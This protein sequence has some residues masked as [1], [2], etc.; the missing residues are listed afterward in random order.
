MRRVATVA[1]AAVIF[2]LLKS[3]L[4]HAAPAIVRAPE[5][6]AGDNRVSGAPPPSDNARHFPHAWTR[7]Q[8]TPEHNAAF[9]VADDAPAWMRR[10]VD[11]R[12]AAHNALP[13]EGDAYQN[14]PVNTTQRLGFA[15]GVSAV[16]G[17]IFAGEG[18]RRVY[19]LDARTGKEIWA[20]AAI[21]E[22]MNTP[23]VADGL[24]FAG[25]GDTG[26]SF[27]KVM[28]FK[29]GKRISRGMGFGGYYALD[30]RT[31]KQV[32]RF[33]TEG[34]AM[35]GAL[36]SDGTLFFATGDGHMYAVEG[37][38]GKL[39]WKTD[40]QGFA[41]MSSLNALGDLIYVG[42]SDPNFVFALDRRSGK[43]VWRQTVPGVAN[44]GMGD[45]SPAVDPARGLVI[46][47]TVVDANVAEKTN[48]LAV[49]AMDAATGAIKWQRKL[50]RGP[51]PPAYKAGVAMVHGD[52][53]YIGS[54]VTNRLYALDVADGGIRWQ[55]PIPNAGKRGAGRGS[56]TYYRD[57]LYFASVDSLYRLDPN[58]GKIEAQR[59]LGGR[60]G[61]VNPVIVGGSAYLANS[62]G[63]V[64][65]V[66]LD[67][68]TERGDNRG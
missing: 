22:V 58:N 42:A 47:S 20:F 7:Y 45:N 36:Y 48:D 19:A 18:A 64:M 1:V 52:R 9:A 51:S 46:Q 2:A 10:G 28:K 37:R 57:K 3:T 13:L 16:D 31:G 38:T 41:S 24:V 65:A 33:D 12:F 66:P 21:N 14:D 67:S 15:V 35:P 54:P 34:N 63:W 23:L 39:R 27:D 29:Q 49:F 6:N 43:I 11:W 32:W 50:G 56:P 40:I 62:W 5:F 68:P 30:A 25:A 44:T 17:M 55:T 59:K 60:F 4:A 8:A 61:I 53:V 26:F